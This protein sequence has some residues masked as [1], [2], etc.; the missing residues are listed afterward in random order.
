MKRRLLPLLAA[1]A[2]LGACATAPAP[3]PITDTAARAPQLGTLARLIR[4]AGLA[5]TLRASGPFTVFAPSDDA[6]KAVPAATMQELARNPQRLKDLLA[7]H[8]LRGRMASGEI[9]NGNAKT[10]H[11]GNVALSRAGAFVTVEDALVTQADLPASNGVVH[12]ID[13][14]LLPPKR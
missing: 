11:G 8:V 4:E 3:A 5:D 7:F 9:S 14:V 12:V 2:V 13:R 6:F 1:A 10:L